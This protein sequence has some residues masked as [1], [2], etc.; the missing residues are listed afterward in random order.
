MNRDRVKCNIFVKKSILNRFESKIRTIDVISMMF[1]Q[2][3]YP[4]VTFATMLMARD[5]QLAQF[6][7]MIMITFIS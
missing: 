3:H 1:H 7:Y 6:I 5:E 4:I 2:I